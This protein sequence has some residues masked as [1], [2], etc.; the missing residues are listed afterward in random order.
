[1]F[2]IRNGFLICPNN[3]INYSTCNNSA[4]DAAINV[5]HVLL[6]RLIYSISM[7]IGEKNETLD[8]TGERALFCIV[9][10]ALWRKRKLHSLIIMEG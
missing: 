6:S 7:S 5:L 3:T 9:T 4:K 8:P 2:R 10:R 1:M